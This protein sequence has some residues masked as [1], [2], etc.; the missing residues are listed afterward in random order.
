MCVRERWWKFIIFMPRQQLAD[1]KFFVVV[2]I[3][4]EEEKNGCEMEMGGRKLRV[5]VC[6][7]RKWVFTIAMHRNQSMFT[8]IFSLAQFLFLSFY[9]SS[10]FFYSILLFCYCYSSICTCVH[11]VDM[12]ISV[13]EYVNRMICNCFAE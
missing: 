10:S 6:A 9:F 13:C 7:M 12:E 8:T 1:V 5:Y 3:T 4:A 2:F 11:A